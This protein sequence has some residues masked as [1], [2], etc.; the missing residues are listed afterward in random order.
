MFSQMCTVS[1]ILHLG[2]LN[3]QERKVLERELSVPRPLIIVECT[4]QAFNFRMELVL[5]LF[6]VGIL[7]LLKESL[8][9]DRYINKSSHNKNVEA[10]MT[11]KKSCST[12][13]KV[14]DCG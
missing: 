8:A 2:I 4:T 1:V 13:V 9:N 7:L 11:F 10:I 3:G 12:V 5:T 14:R 6:L